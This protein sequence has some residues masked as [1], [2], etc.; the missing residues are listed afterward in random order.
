MSRQLSGFGRETQGLG[1]CPWFCRCGYGYS[2]GVKLSS[3]LK[4]ALLSSLATVLMNIQIATFFPYLK[5]DPSELP[6]LIGGFSLGPWAG[7]AIV[8]LKNLIFL[9][10]HFSPQEMFGVSFNTI[11]GIA[12]VG[13]ASGIYQLRK[14]KRMGKVSLVLGV[15]AMTLV[16]IPTQLVLFP[17]FQSW[18]LP[19]Q[20]KLAQ[21]TLIRMILLTFVPFNLLKG[22]ITGLLTYFS[23]K[24][25]SRI[26][27]SDTLWEGKE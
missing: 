13:T 14:S 17:V 23:Y 26:L 12:Y 25:F 6:A 22:S 21:E 9:G 1:R 24:R 18:F 2:C 5:Y 8:V 11:A 7:L 4:V 16:M 3:L 10:T 27:K 20:A 15:I 19:D